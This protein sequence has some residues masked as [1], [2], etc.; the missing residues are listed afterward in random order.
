MQRTTI[1]VRIERERALE[2][3]SHRRQLGDPLG[4]IERQRDRRAPGGAEPV[5]QFD[6]PRLALAAR[7]SPGH[8]VERAARPGK[9]AL[10]DAHAVAASAPMERV[11]ADADLG[12]AFVVAVR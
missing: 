4:T 8:R 5:E 11:G 2:D 3:R 10:E 7:D 12:R 6:V 1:V 9:A